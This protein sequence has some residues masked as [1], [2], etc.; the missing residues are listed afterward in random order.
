MGLGVIFFTAWM[1]MA[2]NVLGF[3][4]VGP[5]QNLQYSLGAVYARGCVKESMSITDETGW[6]TS[7]Q[8]YCGNIDGGDEVAPNSEGER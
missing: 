4:T 3:C 5:I 8:T 6:T 2:N 1:V 7:L